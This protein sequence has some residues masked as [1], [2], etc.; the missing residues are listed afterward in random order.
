MTH[1]DCLLL[2]PIG[3]ETYIHRHTNE[4]RSRS[5]VSLFSSMFHDVELQHILPLCLD[6]V[7]QLQYSRT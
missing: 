5:V 2:K 3:T 4:I 7:A 1:F 6:Y